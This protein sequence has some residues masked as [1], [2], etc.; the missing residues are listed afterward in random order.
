[1]WEIIKEY[2]IEFLL[3]AISSGAVFI[4]KKVYSDF[5]K[6]SEEQ[7]NLK[8]GMVALLHDSLFKNC[9]DCIKKEEITVSE[10]DNLEGLY[11]SYHA[12]GGNGTGTEL[13]ERCKK[14][15]IKT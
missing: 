9:E 2:G 5:K 10:L 3:T 6:E 7:K 11:N 1:M 4:L 13:F 14:L 15:N 8:C 12:L